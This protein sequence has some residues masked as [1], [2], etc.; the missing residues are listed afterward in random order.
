VGAALYLQRTVHCAGA[1]D[2]TGKL[3]AGEENVGGPLCPLGQET[4]PASSD[5]WY[6]ASLLDRGARAALR[7]EDPARRSADHL[8]RRGRGVPEV[9]YGYHLGKVILK[10]L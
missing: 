4:L 8:T 6:L 2:A 1:Y 3:H 9:Q 10:N 5:D 7:P